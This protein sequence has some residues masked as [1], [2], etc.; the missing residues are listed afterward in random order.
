MTSRPCHSHLPSAAR[1]ITLVVSLVAPLRAGAQQQADSM[2]VQLSWDGLTFLVRSDTIEGEELWVS[3]YVLKHEGGMELRWFAGSYDP[4]A[5]ATWLSDVELLLLPDRAGPA[6]PPNQLAVQPLVDLDDGKFIVARRREGKR[7]SASV[8]LSF[9]PKDEP[10]LTFRVERPRATALF[11]ALAQGARQSR[12]ARGSRAC[13][14]S[15]CGCGGG[16]F[17]SAQLISQPPALYPPELANRGTP[18]MVVL[19]FVVDTVGHV[20]DDETLHV[21][22]SPHPAFS[23][24]ARH[25]VA[26]SLYQPGTCSGRPVASTVREP[27]LF[28]IERRGF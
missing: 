1:A 25:L 21:L 28:L 11:A 23:V 13:E 9:N 24:A 27:V 14:G 6:D 7:W 5:V 4:Q 22:A 15:P 20:A 26:G 16:G 10:G 3:A 8:L 17:R 18:G 12:L 19:S 2:A